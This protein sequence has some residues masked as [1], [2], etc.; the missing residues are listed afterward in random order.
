MANEDWLGWYEPGPLIYYLRSKQHVHKKAAGRRKLRLL[1]VAICRTVERHFVGDARSVGRIELVERLADKLVR[2]G[3]VTQLH[4]ST[5]WMPTADVNELAR[6]ATIAACDPIAENAV[7][8]C[9]DF[10]AHISRLETKG[11]AEFASQKAQR[12][13]A[14][15]VR[16]I[17][18]NPFRPVV[19]DPE[20]RT[21]TV[22]QLAQGI[23][24]DRAFDRLPILADALQDA[25]CDNADVLTHCRDT[26]PHARGCWVVDLVLGKA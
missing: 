2:A 13:Q 8:F 11:D 10:A 1:A 26:G 23:Y 16:C 12:V 20:W 24:D 6:R 21:S 19:L 18:G 5:P 4:S 22:V 25:G 7:G 9:G 15:L 14:A 17:F 3:E